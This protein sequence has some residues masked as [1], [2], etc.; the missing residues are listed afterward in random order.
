[1]RIPFKYIGILLLPPSFVRQRWEKKK[2]REAEGK[3]PF[4]ALLKL[5]GVLSGLLSLLSFLASPLVLRF[6]QKEPADPPPFKE[7]RY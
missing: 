6:L 5:C 3:K 1:M 7:K 4:G 2:Q